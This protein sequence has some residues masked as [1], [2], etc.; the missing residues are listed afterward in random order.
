MNLKKM[1]RRMGW[2]VGLLVAFLAG[3][4]ITLAKVQLVDGKTYAGVHGINSSSVPINAARGTI[5]DRNG[6]PLVE[7]RPSVSVVF[8]HPF[9]PERKTPEGQKR[10]NELLASLITLF[11]QHKTP[12]IDSL[13]IALNEQGQAA[14]LPD[15]E[16]EVRELK[17]PE[18]LRLNEYATAQNCMDA[19][20]ERFALES[21][22]PAMARKIASVQYGMLRMGYDINTPYTFAEDADTLLVSK[23]K[24]SSRLYTGVVTEIV[25]IRSYTDGTLAPHI[26]G[27]V[28]AIS[29]SDYAAHKAEGYKL[30]DV[31]GASGIER[32]AEN[33]LRGKEGLKQVM[34]DSQGDASVEIVRPAVQGSSVV[35][36]LDMG[37]QRMIQDRFPKYMEDF[38]N[39]RANV[40]AAGS[41]VVLDVNSFE[42]LACVSYPY[43]D[44]TKYSE[45]LA[46]LNSDPTAPLWDR[47]LRGTYEPGSTIKPSGALAALQEGLITD[48]YTFYCGGT[49]K[50]LDSSY[51]CNQYRMH[52]GRP[53]NVRKALIDSCNSFFYEMGRILGYEKLNT[54]RM[55]MG[56]GQKT[57]VELPEESG[58]MDSEER[59]AL[60]NQPWYAG[61]NIQSGIGQNNL[62]TPM[63]IA[64]YAATIANNG[65]RYRAHFIQSVREAG[66]MEP[67][68]VNT[69][70]ILGE[71]GIDKKYYATIRDAMNFLGSNPNGVTGRYFKNLPV[72]VGAKT[73]TS[74]VVREVDGVRKQITNGI[75][76]SYAPADKPEIAVIAVGEG[77][78]NSEPTIPIIRDVYEYYFGTMDSI[79][80]GQ[81]EAQLLG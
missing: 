79:A 8:E 53:I 30:N 49:Y 25:P 80:K 12:W 31:Y 16:E 44:I 51:K 13:P 42:V 45:Q 35:L 23:I 1:N 48:G 3:F 75:F 9:F 28:G 81:A 24:E 77:C 38:R 36:T 54:Y 60:L 22:D 29:A 10:R 27:R 43:Y 69:P 20:V 15:H 62:F 70:E 18:R 4:S 63:Q 61:Y 65:K 66:T 78:N 58:V 7:N 26:I 11:E 46:A 32:A 39:K 67:V 76:I 55:A 14:F 68:Q 71:T 74:Q 64:V 59:R 41:V 52:G 56:L 72:K 6:I 21:Y 2:L 5:Y 19:L 57:G 50:Y 34:V 40:P 73:G 17:S 33:W 47:A 37:L